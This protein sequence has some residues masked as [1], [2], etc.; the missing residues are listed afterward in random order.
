LLANETPDTF[1]RKLPIGPLKRLPAL[2]YTMTKAP[3]FRGSENII[4]IHI[5]GR[6]YDFETHSC[7]QTPNSVFESRISSAK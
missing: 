2:N 5:D 1:V 3:E 6:F 4:E 7:R